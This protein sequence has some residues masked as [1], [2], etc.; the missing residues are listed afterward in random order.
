MQKITTNIQ[1]TTPRYTVKSRKWPQLKT[2]TS[3]LY[4][5]YLFELTVQDL[6]LA[7]ERLFALRG[8]SVS[9]KNPETKQNNVNKHTHVMTNGGLG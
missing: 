3:D 8:L 5:K 2:S 4:V 1:T 6:D 9:S 7:F